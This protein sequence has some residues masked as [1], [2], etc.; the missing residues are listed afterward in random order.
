MHEGHRKRMLQRLEHAEGL[1]D[2]ELL[3][4]LLFNA[5]PRRN[6]NPLA[7]ELL[8]SFPSMGELFRADYAE[9]LNVD[10]VGPETAAYLRCIGLLME[11][12]RNRRE[13]PPAV[14]SA[15]SFSK[16]LLDRFS[17]LKEEAIEIFCMDAQ[18]RVHSSKRFTLSLSDKAAIS[19]EELNA[20]LT[21]RKPSGIVLAHN[22]PNSPAFP[23]A[24]D[25]KFTA[26]MQ[27]VCSMNHIRLYDHIIVGTDGTYSYFLVGR[28]EEIR[29]RFNFSSIV[30]EGLFRG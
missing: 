17:S 30:G 1:Q 6:T 28:M 25:D 23:S 20:F 12:I 11:R 8:T 10:G 18:E 22:H 7:H 5:I 4:I 29:R 16:Y 21:S 2:H 26:Q 27:V 19:A 13:T 9:L 14:F 15:G 24:E 3:E